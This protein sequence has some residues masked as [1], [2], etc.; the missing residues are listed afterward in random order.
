MSKAYNTNTKVE[1]SWGNVSAEGYVCGGFREKV[2]E[3]LEGSEVTRNGSEEGPTY[4]LEQKDGTKVLKL[5][6]ELDKSN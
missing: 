3:T 5:N 2:T 6:S 4:L 1:W